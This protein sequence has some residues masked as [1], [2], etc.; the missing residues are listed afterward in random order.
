MK[1]ALLSLL[2]AASP[3]F[4]E[5]TFE[6]K[7]QNAIRVA[8]TD[9]LVWAMTASCDKGNDIHQRQCRLVRDRKAKTLIGP[10]LWI[11]G[12]SDALEIGKWSGAKKSVSVAL[13]AC[14]RCSGVDVDGRAVYVMG[15]G[16]P[17]WENN[18]LRATAL[19]DNARPFP[20]EAAAMSWSKSVANAKFQLLVK[21]APDAS[22]RRFAVS[23]KDGM[24][25][26]ILAWRVVKPCDG[27]I[28][29]SSVP[30]GQVE[31]DKKACTTTGGIVI[32]ADAS[33]DA[34]TQS[35][36]SDAMKPVVAA[37]RSCFQKFRMSG[38]AKIEISILAD[39]SV[40]KFEQKGDF[41]GSPT[42]K[43]IDDAMAKVTFPKTRKPKTKIGFPI[44]L[45]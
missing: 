41:D 8:R 29:L 40:E 31:P 18:K 43:C 37:A 24:Q 15:A 9:D 33:A 5:D 14:V 4:A 13:S 10:T 21:V 3:A 44:T 36:V 20:D 27:S 12:D 16:A 45:N 1:A 38:K 2:L 19:Y 26:E 34:L 23:G 22:K 32:P 30:S 11:E 6:A 28:V 7:A 17:K 35:M 39:G 42:A 25:L